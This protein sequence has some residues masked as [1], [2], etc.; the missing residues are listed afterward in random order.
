[1]KRVAASSRWLAASL[2]GLIA[3]PALAQG[4]VPQPQPPLRFD[5]SFPELQPWQWAGLT[6]GLFGSMVLALVLERVLLAAGLRLAKLTVSRWDDQLVAA[7]R[8]PLR[9]TLWGALI[10]MG[11]RLLRLPAGAQRP[12][13]L[14]VRS[15]VIISLAW[16]FQRALSLLGEFFDDRVTHEANQDPSK[17]RALRTQVVVLRHFF[18]VAT[19]IIG[20]ALLL[21]QFDVVRNV[22]VSLLASAGIAGLVLGLAAQK[23]ISTLLAG[24][25]LSITQPIRIGD[26]VVVEGESG[27]VEEITLTYVVVKLWDLRRLVLP[28]NYFLEKP[29]QNWSKGPPELLGTVVLEV[30]YSA[31]VDAFRAELDQVLA[32]DAARA[33]WNGQTKKIHVTQAT[34]RVKTVRVLVSAADFDAAF[35]L[36]CL[37]RERL[38]AF[39]ARHPEW[40]P[41][42]RSETRTTEPKAKAG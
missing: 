13:D 4:A 14:L 17:V 22:G 8:G 10:G 9:L 27:T 5:L 26:F 16:F 11:S 40:L 1:M 29:F 21:L 19:Y 37:V 36:R 31:D 20:A 7:G 39:L 35:E 2:A 24:I 32:G 42:T 15:L 25:Q 6:L 30:D 12:V 23:S 34:D 18:E 41:V 28:I 38:T 33:L 3:A